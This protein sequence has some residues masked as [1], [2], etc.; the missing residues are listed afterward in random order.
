[1]FKLKITPDRHNGVQK[2]SYLLL[3][4]LRHFLLPS[5]FKVLYQP[6]F[7][8]EDAVNLTLESWTDERLHKQ[9][10]VYVCWSRD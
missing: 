10:P 7:M 3:S 5:T 4:D 6:P 8:S 9:S 2:L 1:M